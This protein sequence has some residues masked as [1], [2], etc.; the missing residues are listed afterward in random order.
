MLNLKTQAFTL[1]LTILTLSIINLNPAF[2]D[3]GLEVTAKTDKSS[4][5]LREEVKV[6]GNVTYNNEN[7]TEGFASIQIKNPLGSNIL[8][9]TIPVSSVPSKSWRVKITSAYP[10]NQVGNPKTNFERGKWAYF[11]MTVENNEVAT[12]QVLMTVTILDSNQILIGTGATTL[13]V[14]PGKTA[15]YIAAIW[16][17]YW[18]S[19]GTASAYFNAYTDYPENNGYPYCPEKMANFTI[20]ESIY[21]E[22]PVNP[23]PEQPILDGSYQTQFRLSP[24]PTPG[25]YTVKVCAWYKGWRSSATTTFQVEDVE[26]PPRACFVTLPPA[27]GPNQTIT[28]DASYSSPEGYKDTITSYLWDFGD[29]TKAS[30][31]IVTHSYS[32]E[33][34]YTVTLN[35]TDSEGYWNT[36]SK[37][38][39]VKIIHD[40]AVTKMECLNEIYNNWLAKIKVTIENKGTLKETFNLTV[41]NNVTIIQVITIADLDPFKEKTVTIIW[42]TTGITPLTNYIIWA[43]AS[44]LPEEINATNNQ[45]SYGFVKIKLLGD[46][47]FD[48]HIDI[49]DVVKVAVVYDLEE[50][51]PDWDP[52]ADLVP[53]GVIDISDIVVVASKY[54]ITY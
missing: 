47:I 7:V 9:R 14:D 53:D 48:R 8:F 32:N 38:V 30:G 31:K 36:T 5:I 18:A 3:T 51:S 44:S 54:D 2:S 39:I 34:N 24:E 49:S 26:A 40:V 17:E 23:P 6:Y 15:T 1:I 50:G 33:G 4:Y 22:V 35:V 41:Y 25:T 11:E 46:V 37:K 12:Q 42:N 29:E 28:F 10:C 21:E 27:A 16:I 52:Q 13:T 19:T 45:L 20:I 43:E